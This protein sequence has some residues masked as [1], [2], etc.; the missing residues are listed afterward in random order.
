[1]PWIFLTIAIAGEIVGTLS[2]KASEGFTKIGFSALAAAGYIV[3][4]YF[5]SLVLKTI[6]VGIAYAIW[7]GVGVAT[8][9]ILG[10]FLFGQTLDLAAVIGITL[11][12]AGVVILNTLSGSIAH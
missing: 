7:A 11:I 3:A 4:F 6:P 5:L 8:V 10:V 1:M 2:L 9:S 12:V